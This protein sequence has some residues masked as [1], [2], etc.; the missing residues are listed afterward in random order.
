MKRTL[1]LIIGLLLIMTSCSDINSHSNH[2]TSEMPNSKYIVAERI[3]D[4]EYEPNGYSQESIFLQ[5]FPDLTFTRNNIVELEIN[6]RDVLESTIG[7]KGIYLADINGDGFTDLALYQDRSKGSSSRSYLVKIYDYHNDEFLFNDND[8][9]NAILDLD[10]NNVLIIEELSSIGSGFDELERA[11][12]FLKGGTISFEWYHFDFKLK[13]MFID[14]SNY[15]DGGFV[16]YLNQTIYARLC[17][18]GIGSE[19]IENAIPIDDIKVKENPEYYSYQVS[20]TSIA[21]QFNLNYFFVK[22]GSIELEVSIGEVVAKENIS[23]L[24]TEQ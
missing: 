13:G 22:E 7:A 16:A 12:R 6:G 8:N 18:Y 21:S 3:Y 11:G 23:I 24:Q 19:A 14:I 17:M 4:L 1:L 5:E 10:E 9:K 2:S 20:Q 15:Q